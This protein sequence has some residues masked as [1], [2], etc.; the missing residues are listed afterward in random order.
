MTALTIGVVGGL[1]VA[2]GDGRPLRITSR[3]AQALLGCLA[4]EPG[5][6]L[7]RDFL[8]S[9]LWE[10]SD[11][12]LGRA[13]LRQALAAL[14]KALP[15]DHADALR[16]DTSSV[17]L[18]PA[19][20]ATDLARFRASLRGGSF[21]AG[22]AE[23]PTDEL[24]AG[25]D[26]KSVAFEQWLEQQRSAFRRQRI[27]ALEHVAARC[28]AANDL[29]GQRAALER[30]LTLEPVHERAHRTLMDVLARQGRWT[31]ALRQY[32]Q[33]RELLR[34]ELD[35][36]TEPA[37]DALY[38]DL[39]RRRRQTDPAA[40]ED[41]DE[42]ATPA[43]DSAEPTAVAAPPLLRDAVVLCVRL[44]S[45]QRD[46]DIE[47]ART[48]EV[49]F[50]REVTT[51][52][53]RF[54]GRVDRAVSGEALAVFGLEPLSGNEAAR[55]ARA[56]LALVTDSR[57]DGIAVACGIDAG[58]VLPSSAEDRVPVGG[59]TVA[60]ARDLARA[61][62]SGEVL[63]SDGMLERMRDQ[64]D[65]EAARVVGVPSAHRITAHRDGGGARRPFVG[66]RAELALLTSLL[67]RV[68]GSRRGRVVVVRG[69]PGIGKSAII[70]S[71]LQAASERGVTSCMAPVFDF[72]QTTLERPIPTL[73][74][75]LLGLEPGRVDVDTGGKLEAA[76]SAGLVGP[77]DR[78][79]L[80]ELLGATASE[81]GCLAGMDGTARER[82]RALALHR[83]AQRVAAAPLLIV[84]EDAHWAEPAELAA[85]A[86]LAAALS[87]QP[88]LMV[89]SVRA[90][91]DPLDPAWRARIRG[92][93]MTT[94]DLAPLDQDECRELAAAHGDW[95]PELLER[96]LD[97]AGGHP[98]FLEQLLRASAS[99]D[100]LL[101]GSVRALL[102]RRIERLEPGTQQALQAAAVLGHRFALEALRHLLGAPAF[103]AGALEA[104][105]LVVTDADER[106]FAHALIRDAVYESLLGSTRRELHRRAAAWFAPRDAGLGADHL[107]AA[108]DAAASA[109]YARAA[110]EQLQACR[111]ER[112]LVYAERACE[113]AHDPAQHAA[114]RA[115]LGD[116]ELGLGRAGQACDRYRN[117]IEL[118]GDA[119]GRARGWLGLATALRIL[120]RHEE[121]L[122]ALEHAARDLDPHDHRRQARLWT[123]RGNLHFPRG[124]LDLC[125][126]SHR[127]A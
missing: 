74:A 72:G 26:A 102:L 80:S 45:S 101:P 42:V 18:D 98:L 60:A 11:P 86:D 34:R 64:F 38:R 106:R 7:G 36:A 12:E 79:F 118:A 63:V 100:R 19:R 97:L 55:A 47:Q 15:E 6:P 90:D 103:D 77:E 105:G 119:E 29:E 1:R 62:G 104:S 89:L 76:V 9:L 83:L 14:R 125:L 43:E 127:R 108:G 22:A 39:L 66:R 116:V 41:P 78:L 126:E 13:S 51:V 82:G 120:D 2:S 87:S 109:A 73:A 84:V 94:L 65:H 113:L 91:D 17:W 75:R 50:A 88:V 122:A 114:A 57:A 25:L 32:R 27:E 59:H 49:A 71:L 23:V 58:Q 28:A 110:G 56:A 3:K 40:P 33:C 93:P 30:L 10:E 20:A 112:A 21:D 70:E 44:A 85:L 54:G 99:G 16:S 46:L 111:L 96:C 48:R 81:A 4:L 117:A 115:T 61:A 107:A 95:P 8:A 37:T 123:L 124:E 5:T 69:E 121:A 24:L 31:E 68:S 52:I 53:E 67:E 35:V 92:C